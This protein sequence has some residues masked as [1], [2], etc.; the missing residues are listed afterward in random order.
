VID[1]A[2]THVGGNKIQTHAKIIKVSI[3]L[4]GHEIVTRCFAPDLFD[5][6]PLQVFVQMCTMGT[7]CAH[8][9]LLE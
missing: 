9:E 6:S 3:T 7:V 2:T 5:T 1:W 8:G 4:A